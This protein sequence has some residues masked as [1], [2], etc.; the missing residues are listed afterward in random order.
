M[1]NGYTQLYKHLFARD[2]FEIYFLLAFRALGFSM[3]GIFLPL[4]LL[5]DLGFSLT[6]VI[7]FFLMTS[8]SF[9]IGNYFALGLIS[10]YGAKHVMVWS[11]FFLIT[12]FILTY[13]LESFPQ[14]YL[15]AAFYQGLSMG[16]FWMGFHVDASLH[17]R[18]KAVGKQSGLILLVSILGAVLGPVIGGFI[19]YYFGF[20]I[21]F[22]VAIVVFLIS[23][24]PFL[25]SKDLYVKTDFDFR[26]LFVREH[27]KYFF[28]YFAQGVRATAATVFWPIFIFSIFGSYVVLGSY[29]A[30]AT[31]FTGVLCYFVGMVADE[32]KK[33]V[34]IRVSGPLEAVTW[35]A[36]LFVSS[37]TSVFL[38]GFLGGI[39]SVGVDV[40]L[41]AKTYGRT[42]KEKAAAFLFF[43]EISLRC[44]EIFTLLL[45][46]VLGV[47]SSSFIAASLS[48]LLYLL[49]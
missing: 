42:K 30:L 43:R 33:E 29:G 23:I 2:L 32:G 49:F 18:K 22:L 34:L 17:S 41:L 6:K 26:S 1:F 5:H 25:F 39:T 12:G 9:A 45:V 48:S 31:L 11:Y 35:I 37:I 40:P 16:L 27:V 44:G 36:R 24:V 10:R 15:T 47:V 7:G 20:P 8:V 21:L 38:V 4:F 3:I 28:G 13:F 19:L 14:L 46:L